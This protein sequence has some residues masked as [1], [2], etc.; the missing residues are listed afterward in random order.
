MRREEKSKGDNS[1][2][3]GESD[4]VGGVTISR[5]SGAGRGGRTLCRGRVLTHRTSRYTVSTV[6]V[7]VDVN[8][9]CT[10]LRLTYG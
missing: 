5:R 6:T 10:Y 1:R 2:G 4:R 7:T 9:N 3:G 8:V